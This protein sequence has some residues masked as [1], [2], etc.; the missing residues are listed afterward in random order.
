MQM[1]TKNINPLNDYE[2]GR[3]HGQKKWMTESTIS[4]KDEKS[5]PKLF[6]FIF[7]EDNTQ[8]LPSSITVKAL[9]PISYS[10]LNIRKSIC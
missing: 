7:R 4:S 2:R 10:L 9:W 6:F 1:P 5:S 8:S 3:K